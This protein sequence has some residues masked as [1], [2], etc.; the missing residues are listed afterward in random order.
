MTERNKGILFMLMSSLFFAVMASA[1]KLAGDLPTME[2][3]FFRNVVGF[4]F[5]GALI[6]RQGGSFTGTDRKA[7]LYRSFFGFLGLV[8]YF[9]AIDRLPL[10]NAVILNQMNPFITM[11]L[12]FIFLRE[13]VLKPQW[14]ALML[15]MAG[16][17]LIIRPGAG[18][19]LAP[20]LVGLLSAF[21]AAAAYTVI[22]HLRLTDQPMTIVFYFTGFTTL[23]TLPFML[24]GDFV[25][26]SAYQLLALL[27]VGVTAT[28]AQFFMTHA[29]RY[30]EAG[31]LSIYSY[32]NTIFSMFIAL[33]LWREFPDFLSLAGVL[34]VI[35][36]AY[37]NWRARHEVSLPEE[38]RRGELQK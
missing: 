1:V 35:C 24:V 26:P 15:A 37:L 32:G 11:V 10:A 31:D 23:A 30:A 12:A 9:Y 17:F 14:V 27:T 8:C 20:A 28:I 34:L 29:Y 7:L 5:S 19:T 38:E 36:G 3:V 33:L 6:W 13:K 16:I 4:L 22:R 2:K 25:V 18:Y 21:F